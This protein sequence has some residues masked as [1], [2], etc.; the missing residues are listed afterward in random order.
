MC[1]SFLQVL[2]ENV[3][4]DE[5]AEISKLFNLYEGKQ[6]AEAS[7]NQNYR[8]NWVHNQCISFT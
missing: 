1:F 3:K 8:I 2:K 7:W 6:A 5:V 4:E